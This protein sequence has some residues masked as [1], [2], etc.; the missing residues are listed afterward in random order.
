MDHSLLS[1][2]KTSILLSFIAGCSS[3]DLDEPCRGDGCG[4]A[5]SHAELME[6]L[7]PNKDPI[8]EYLREN[9]SEN[10]TLGSN[11]QET[12]SGIFSS[13]GCNIEE[14]KNFVV[15]SNTG[16]SPKPVWASC[17]Q[18]SNRASRVLVTI[19]YL[20]PDRSDIDTRTMHL[21]AWDANANEYRRYATYPNAETGALQVSVSPV[22]CMS[23]HGGNTKW[24]PLMNEMVNPWSQWIAEP[25][26]KS[27]LFDGHVPPELA[28]A[29]IFNAL[30]VSSAS[31]SEL[32]PIVRSGIQRVTNSRLLGRHSPPNIES[33][34]ELLR[35]L[36]CDETV[37]YVSE[38][39]R[40]G[41]LP[42]NVWVDNSTRTLMRKALPDQTWNWQS[43]KQTLPAA[44]RGQ[45]SLTLV[46]IRGISTEAVEM[47][48]VSRNVLTPKQV[49]RVRALDWTSPVGSDFRC[50]LFQRQTARLKQMSLLDG[51]GGSNSDLIPVLLESIL[52]EYKVPLGSEL[53]SIS[54]PSS[55]PI[56]MTLE[57]FG[58]T[59]DANT[60]QNAKRSYVE[61]VRTRRACKIN[62]I[63]PNA[64]LVPDLNCN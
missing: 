30:A 29:K 7:E 46:P 49:L 10:G 53:V 26:F 48:L 21:A 45:P 20:L 2:S 17:T 57:E 63:F 60:A 43:E 40:N 16:L 59:L 47:A 13:A 14:T 34:I 39:H 62:R 6:R 58:R 35:P 23:C 15:L 9:V 55:P 36:F 64:S 18:E 19:P 56:P 24:Q 61:E 12:L 1:L 32:E 38:S 44:R 42:S 33:S 11:F 28:E 51:T 25:G 37:N 31:A 4:G 22:F 52:D 3:V 8:A 27:Q 5:S 50:D 54:S 41:E